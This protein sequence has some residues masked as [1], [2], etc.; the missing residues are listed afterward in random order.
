MHGGSQFDPYGSAFGKTEQVPN[1][2]NRQ[3]AHRQTRWRGM[4]ACRP[5]RD[6]DPNAIAID[7]ENLTDRDGRCQQTETAPVQRMGWVRNR[8]LVGPTIL[9]TN[10]CIKVCARTIRDRAMTN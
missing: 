7:D 4:Q 8:Y 1:A 3:F 2:I 9:Q 6:P 5:C 10:W